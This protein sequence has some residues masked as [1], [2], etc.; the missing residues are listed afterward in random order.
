LW[1]HIAATEIVSLCEQ[2][3]GSARFLNLKRR[4]GLAG[5]EASTGLVTSMCAT[6]LLCVPETPFSIEYWR[7]VFQ[8]E[9]HVFAAIPV[10][11]LKE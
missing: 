1:T 8:V 4:F 6:L 2:M 5:N 10:A 7:E 9:K 11:Q 3:K